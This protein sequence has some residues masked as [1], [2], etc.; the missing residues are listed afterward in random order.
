MKLSI[1]LPSRRRY[2]RCVQSIDTL[3]GKSSGDNKLEVLLG[4]DNDDLDTLEQCKSYIEKTYPNVEIKVSV[5]ERYGYQHL[6][7]YINVSAQIKK[8]SIKCMLILLKNKLY[9]KRFR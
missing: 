2:K 1:L 6:N 4:F 8:H 5:T 7:K 9:L 3:I